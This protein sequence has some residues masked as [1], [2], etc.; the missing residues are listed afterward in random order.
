MLHD[1]KNS[2][3]GYASTAAY[4]QRTISR[5]RYQHAA[6]ASNHLNTALA[7]IGIVRGILRTTGKLPTELVSIGSFMKA[8]ISE[9][10]SW[11][12]TGVTISPPSELTDV[13]VWSNQSR[14]HSIISNLARNSVEAMN[15]KGVFSIDCDMEGD[16][17][18]FI[19]IGDTGPG[20]TEQQLFSLNS[21]NPLSSSK[22]HGQGL[23]LLTVLLLVKE[24][25]GS[26][27][28]SRPK[29]GG[30]VT[31]IWI[32]SNPPEEIDRIN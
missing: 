5:E 28:F 19:A 9:L 25:N 3:L 10:W 16:N 2:I 12:P 17:G 24:L 22:K 11:F 26:V 30:C 6:N 1:L 18:I 14:L 7:T 32:P 29:S 21:G 27:N 20:L 31:N 23:G 13:T 4:A 15:G 8:M